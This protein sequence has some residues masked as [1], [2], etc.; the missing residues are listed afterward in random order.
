MNQTV[1]DNPGLMPF[2]LAYQ[3]AIIGHMFRDFTFFLKCL[4]LVPHDAFAQDP[5]TSEMVKILYRFYRDMEIPRKFTVAEFEGH[6][7]YCFGVD[8]KV[9]NNYKNKLQKCLAQADQIGLDLLSKDMT[10]WL[11]LIKAVNFV[12]S[13]KSML[14]NKEYAKVEPWFKAMVND[15]SS[16]SFLA[17]PVVTFDGSSDFYK[18]R[19]LDRANCCTLGHPLFDDLVLEGSSKLANVNA[20]SEDPNILKGRSIKAITNGGLLLGDTTILV[21]PTNS[22]KTTAVITIAAWNVMMGKSVLYIPLEQKQDDL[23]DNIYRSVTNM[24]RSQISNDDY[25]INES[26][27]TADYREIANNSFLRPFLVFSPYI[28]AGEMYVENVIDRIRVLREERI[29]ET[30]KGF[31]LVIVDYPGKLQAKAFIGKKSG[32]WAETAYVYGQLM[33][34]GLECNHHSIL[35]AQTNRDGAKVNRGDADRLL[36]ETD[37]GRSFGVATDA[38]NVITINRS[39][40]DI[41]RRTVRFHVAKCRAAEKGWTFLSASEY[42]KARTHG[43][44]LAAMKIGPNKTMSQETFNNLFPVKKLTKEEEAQRAEAEAALRATKVV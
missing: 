28:K 29:Q 3:Q 30:G 22:G 44:G 40:D 27:T 39:K 12:N 8:P 41:E 16:T 38:D 42:E 20:D 21:G 1:T 43:P 37:I 6:I 23:K 26:Q 34:L 24:T 33:T 32:D 9:S 25:K 5:D 11:K 13:A 15:M 7:E 2:S 31:D 36:D 17:S 18:K 10:G 4:A 35:P 14:N 19:K